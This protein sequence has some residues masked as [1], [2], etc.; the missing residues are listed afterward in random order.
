[1]LS[2]SASSLRTVDDAAW[3]PERST[4]F[5]EPTGCPVA[6]Y[7]ST[8]RSSISC[9][10]SDSSICIYAGTLR[11]QLGCH[12]PAEEAPAWREAQ[13][14]AIASGGQSEHLEP[15]ERVFVD[16]VLEARQRERLVEPE[17]EHDLLA[18]LDTF[19]ERLHVASRLLPAGERPQVVGQP[20]RVPQA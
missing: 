3:I 19:V 14:P 8:T 17:P 11:Q 13:C 1:M 12:A 7:S 5:F 2:S 16:R 6:T 18:V 9:C 15:V 10:R 4:S 20:R